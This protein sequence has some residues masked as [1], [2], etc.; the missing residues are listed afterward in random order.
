MD[1]LFLVDETME[2][3]DI[4]IECA[5]LANEYETFITASD[6]IFENDNLKDEVVKLNFESS[7]NEMWENIKEKLQTFLAKVGQFFRMLW[8][9]VKETFVENEYKSIFLPSSFDIKRGLELATDKDT[10]EV[11]NW[12]K[13]NPVLSFLGDI[14]SIPK[15]LKAI[16]D[17]GDDLVYGVMNG[18]FDNESVELNSKIHGMYE[19]LTSNFKLPK[20]PEDKLP[21]VT[22]IRENILSLYLDKSE[23]KKLKTVAAKDFVDNNFDIIDNIHSMNGYS[24]VKGIC[25]IISTRSSKLSVSLKQ[26]DRLVRKLSFS[27][28]EEDLEKVK[29]LK[30]N[31]IKVLNNVQSLCR[32]IG[33][34]YWELYLNI[35]TDVKKA[36][37]VFVKLAE[38]EKHK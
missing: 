8:I 20:S 34:T 38:S 5:S 3:S 28:D 19:V 29:F 2:L 24:S 12:K 15:V 33:Q 25:D 32:I 17:A 36:C 22:E 27:Q 23:D 6:A 7:S 31:T 18:K 26:A 13:D 11:K 21:T 16:Y 14:Y 9:K 10:I 1:E 35:R 30:S 37:K 4:M